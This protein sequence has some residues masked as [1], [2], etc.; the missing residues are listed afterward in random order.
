MLFLTIVPCFGLPLMMITYHCYTGRLSVTGGSGENDLIIQVR[1]GERDGIV[2]TSFDA[3]AIT[4]INKDPNVSALKRNKSI[5]LLPSHYENLS[6]QPSLLNAADRGMI[7][8]NRDG[9]QVLDYRGNKIMRSDLLT[10][11]GENLCG[12][13]T[14]KT[15]LLVGIGLE[16]DVPP[17]EQVNY[18]SQVIMTQNGIPLRFTHTCDSN[19]KRHNLTWT[20]TMGVETGQATGLVPLRTA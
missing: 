4:N 8:V 10:A 11:N 17:E 18:F 19:S 15:G 14:D 9:V 3:T 16:D 5:V 6:G 12:Y 7:D 20:L 2:Q 13:V 1:T